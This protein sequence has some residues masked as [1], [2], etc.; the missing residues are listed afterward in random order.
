MGWVKKG[1]IFNPDGSG[2]WMHNSVLTPTPLLLGDE[3]IRIY[4]SFRD[5]EGRGRIGFLDLDARDPSRILSVGRVPVLD[6]GRPGCF[7]DNGMLLGDIVR[8]G[9]QVY[10]YYVG[11]QITRQVKFLAFS[12]LAISVD[13]GKSF[14]RVS[15]APVMDRVDNGLFIRAIHTVLAEGDV[16]RIW[17]AAGNGWRTIDGVDYPEYDIRYTE[18]PDGRHFPDACGRPVLGCGPGEYR[19]GRPRV[20][21]V[22]GG[23]EM[24]FTFDTLDKQY[25]TGKAYSTDGLSWT[26]SDEVDVPRSASG[27]D[28]R[29]VS[30]PCVLDTPHGRY[31]FYGG[32]GMGRDGF[33]YAVWSP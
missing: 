25:T 33:G 1:R 28:S 15:S 20:R 12:G 29:E 18:S 23:Y 17:Y 4:A 10:M 30:Y 3:T 26:R 16:F 24:R 7:D 13:G 21:K 19:I 9:D 22:D 11:F 27:W 5:R 6:L 8:V 2:D 31:M 14:E 32:N